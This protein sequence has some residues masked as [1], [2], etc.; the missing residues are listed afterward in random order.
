MGKRGKAPR[1][2]T[3]AFKAAAVQRAREEVAAG[4]TQSSVARALGLN[5]SVLSK[6]MQDAE[7]AGP[8]AASAGETPEQELRRL[9]REVETLRM[10]RDF[11]KKAAA[12]FARDVT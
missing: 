12:Y 6:W 4:G 10:E 11:A 2:F 7:A 9:R 5:P 8:T 1:V 3:P